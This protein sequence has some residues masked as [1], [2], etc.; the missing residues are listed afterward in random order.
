[1]VGEREAEKFMNAF[2]V[3]VLLLCSS[4]DGQM[5]PISVLLSQLLCCVH[6]IFAI[7]LWRTETKRV[8]ETW[9]EL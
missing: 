9:R 7:F 8:G 4:W 2:V 5:K 3:L 6:G 1:M